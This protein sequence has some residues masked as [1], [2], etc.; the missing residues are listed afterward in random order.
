MTF[1]GVW[2]T[3]VTVIAVAM[4]IDFWLFYLFKYDTYI[5]NIDCDILKKDFTKIMTRSN[6]NDQIRW[7]NQGKLYAACITYHEWVLKLR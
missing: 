2:V 6:L 5:Q 1:E 7:W 4:H 3:P